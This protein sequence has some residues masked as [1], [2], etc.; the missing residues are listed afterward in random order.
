MGFLFAT[1][2]S[3]IRN[4]QLNK[5]LFIYHKKTK[6]SKLVL[7]FL[8]EN[9]FILGY[10]FQNKKYKIFLKYVKNKPVIKTMQVLSKL[11][12]KIYLS[13]KQLWKI[14]VSNKLLL[15]STTKGL[16]SLKD[17]KKQNMAGELVVIIN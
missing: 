13:T 4:A 10:F 9:N 6:L 2:L 14:K 17:C 5:K 12:K 3:N 15:I 8:W 1:L 11:N 7:N 16:K